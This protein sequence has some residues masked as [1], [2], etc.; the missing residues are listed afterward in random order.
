MGASM[1]RLAVLANEYDIPLL[2]L[3]V[4]SATFARI[5]VS[6]M[7]R[8]THLGAKSLRRP[9]C[10]WKKGWPM[11]NLTALQVLDAVMAAVY[12]T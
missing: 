6:R 1:P 4:S 3:L 8:P 7:T 11:R 10:L 9:A 5:T 2:E 12:G